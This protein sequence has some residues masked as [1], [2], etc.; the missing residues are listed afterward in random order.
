MPPV[1]LRVCG[2]EDALAIFA[3]EEA[4][5]RGFEE[6]ACNAVD[7]AGRG[8]GRYVDY[9]GGDAHDGAW[10]V[11]V[12]VYLSGYGHCF[13][14]GTVFLVQGVHV[15]RTLADDGV[16]FENQVGPF[17]DLGTGDCREGVLADA[18]GELYLSAFYLYQYTRSD[19]TVRKYTAPRTSRKEG[20]LPTMKLSCILAMHLE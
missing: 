3:V 10:S 5:P 17:G 1:V 7:F 2:G 6:G 19:R 18:V 20:R 16:V 14:K 12:S 13:N 8:D 11:V 9:I 15:A 4:V